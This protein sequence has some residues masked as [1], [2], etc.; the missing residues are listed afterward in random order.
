MGMNREFCPQGK[1]CISSVQKKEPGFEDYR[2]TAYLAATKLGFYAVRNPEDQGITQNDF[3]SILKNEYPV[4]IL[5]VG[6]KESDVVKKEYKIAKENCLPIFIFIKSYNDKINDK[7]KKIIKELS[8]VDYNFNCSKFENCENL[9]DGIIHKLEEY[10]KNKNAVINKPKLE[11]GVGLA[12]RANELLMKKAKRQIIIY[13]S[14]SILLLGPRKGV[15]YEFSFYRQL[16]DWFT[17]ADKDVEF[18]HVFNWEETQREIKDH[19][20]FYELDIARNNITELYQRFK[21]EEKTI[22]SIRYSGAQNSTPYVITDT[23]I[24]FVVTIEEERYTIELP[25]YIMSIEEINKIKD[26]LYLKTIS[27]EIDKIKEIYK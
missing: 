24:V 26:E 27:I 4:F 19:A 10:I 15:G 22:F 6:V 9:Y 1:L 3:E 11:K 8:K 21:D 16:L 12:Y 18:L 2:Y 14:T 5:L 25:T 7:T 17:Y 23:N 20:E 13:Q